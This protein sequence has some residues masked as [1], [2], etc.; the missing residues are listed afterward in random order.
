MKYNFKEEKLDSGF[1]KEYSTIANKLISASIS[2]TLIGM[3]GVCISTFLRYLA[4]QE[5]AHFVYLDVRALSTHTN[6]EF[7]RLLLQELGYTQRV[8]NDEDLLTFCRNQLSMLSKK[9]NRIVIIIN[10]FHHLNESINRGL[11]SNLRSLHDVDKSKIVFVTTALKPFYELPL[12]VIG[13][14]NMEL[15][16]KIVYFRPY[17]LEDMKKILNI[18][19]LELRSTDEIPAALEYAGGHVN[20]L[21]LLLRTDYLNNPLADPFI[22][23]QLKMIYDGFTSSQ[24]RQIQ[25]LVNGKRIAVDEYLYQLGMLKEAQGKKELFSPLMQQY[26]ASETPQKLSNKESKLFF[27]LKKNKNKIVSKDVI[28][29]HVWKDEPD[30]ASDW[31][32]NALVY[33]LR[34][35]PY[36]INSGYDIESYKGRGYKIVANN[37]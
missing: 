36:Y 33:R 18:S 6:E 2:F 25:Q 37:H 13:D 21:Q 9:H 4:L 1:C 30:E 10:R 3:E 35:T 27:L 11:L 12:E 31:A 26:I 5:Y 22:K 23:L 32:L 8:K 28:F 29:S 34:K 20:L 19:V 24:K 7:F 17:S 15:F 14:S 16:S